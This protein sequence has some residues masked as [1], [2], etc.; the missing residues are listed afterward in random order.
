MTNIGEG[1]LEVSGNP[2]TGGVRQRAWSAAQGPGDLPSEI[3]GSP[4]VVYESADGHNHF[5]LKSAMRYSLWN[6][7]KTAQVAPGQKVGFCLYDIEDAPSP[8]PAQDPQEYTFDVTQFCDTGE[9]SATDLRMGTSSGWRDVYNKNLAYQWIDVSN[10]APG[11]YVVGAEADPE[12]RIWEGGGSR[13]SNAP[14]F[15][16]SH[17]VTVPGWS[18]QPVSV[19]QTGGAQDLTLAST[20]SGTQSNANL[21]YRIQSGPAHGSLNVAVGAAFNPATQKLTY[22]PSPGYTG[23]DSFTFAAFSS[24]SSF[25]LNP[26]VSSVSLVGATPSVA[27]SGAPS[28]LV[29]KAS[30]QL[31]ATLANLPAGVAWTATA[32]TISSSGLYSAPAAP[33]PGGAAVVTATSTAN[34]AVSAQVSIAITPTPSAQSKPGVA[35]TLTAGNRLLSRIAVGH[36]GRRV[37]VGKVVTGAKGGKVTITAT[38][39]RRVLG[40][41]IVK[42]VG[43]RKAVTCKITLKR[44]YPLRKVR[45]TANF[46]TAGGKT[47]VRRSFVIT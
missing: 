43:A 35:G 12:N 5:H 28:S 32:G 23:S 26:P 29:A 47:A 39:K 24:S 9:P 17:Q 3:V 11:T 44:A 16:T 10:T 15:A 6:L 46:T 45:M 1:P 27:I 21:R 18:A 8:A 36:I 34:P 7:A 33:P 31:S 13:E 42:R 20:K 38:L 19:A 37:V 4:E 30:V 40:R 41:C 14:A 25:P 2:Q 22:T